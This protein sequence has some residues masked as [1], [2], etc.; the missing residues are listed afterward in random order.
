M[1]DL[2]NVGMERDVEQFIVSASKHDFSCVTLYVEQAAFGWKD[3]FPSRYC[4]GVW[5]ALS[6]L[7]LCKA[8]IFAGNL[9]FKL[10]IIMWWSNYTKYILYHSSV[11]LIEKWHRWWFW[12]GSYLLERTL[13]LLS[14]PT[15]DEK[16][17]FSF[18]TYRPF[19]AISCLTFELVTVIIFLISSWWRGGTSTGGH[20]TRGA[21]L[22]LAFWTFHVLSVL[23]CLP[24]CNSSSNTKIRLRGWLRCSPCDCV[25]FRY[26]SIWV[27]L[28]L[29]IAPSV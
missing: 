12:E 22:S 21:C 29:L 9:D 27:D 25:S 8:G 26:K 18:K 6:P 10:H 17:L 5:A 19:H 11:I 23:S 13:F 14:G 16:G 4:S 20:F 2:P 7:I 28:G 1:P 24:V 15:A 3:H